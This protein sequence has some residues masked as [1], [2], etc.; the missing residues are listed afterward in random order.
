METMSLTIEGPPGSGK[1]KMLGAIQDAMKECGFRIL[2]SVD[3]NTLEFEVP[4][5]EVVGDFVEGI[6]SF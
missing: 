2:P 5:P 1:T 4:A 6:S 3:R